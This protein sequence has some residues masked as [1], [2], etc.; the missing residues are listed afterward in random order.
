MKFFLASAL[1]CFLLTGCGQT[2]SL[3]LTQAHQK[4]QS[5]PTANKHNIIEQAP[6]ARLHPLP[7]GD[8]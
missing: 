2:G 3:Y 4:E 7:R 1:L 6:S 8:K 5:S